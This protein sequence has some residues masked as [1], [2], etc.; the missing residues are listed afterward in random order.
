MCRN[1]RE[2]GG[3][4]AA[5]GVTTAHVYSQSLVT[6]P[7]DQYAQYLVFIMCGFKMNKHFRCNYE[8]FIVLLFIC[9]KTYLLQA[10]ILSRLS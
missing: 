8:F 5:T 10:L 1:V 7:Y 6:T 9:F 4:G 3:D 2:Y